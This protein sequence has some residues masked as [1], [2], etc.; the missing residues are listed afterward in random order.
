MA[1]FDGDEAVRQRS[2]SLLE[3]IARIVVDTRNRGGTLRIG[4]HAGMLFAAYPDTF[5]VGRIID[6]LVLAATREKVPSEIGREDVE[7]PRPP[8]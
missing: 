3:A 1:R 6:E 5:S 8:L 4:Y 2:V 7:G